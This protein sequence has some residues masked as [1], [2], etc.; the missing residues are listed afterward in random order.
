M[1]IPT[2]IASITLKEHVESVSSDVLPM[3]LQEKDTI[4]TNANSM[5]MVWHMNLSRASSV[6]MLM[7]AD[8]AR[9]RSPAN[10]EFQ[11]KRG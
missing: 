7:A 4:R 5:F 3:L 10:Q 11:A 1:R 2:L 6:L 9:L 8:Y